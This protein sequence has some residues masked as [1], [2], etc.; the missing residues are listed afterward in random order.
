M[1]IALAAGFAAMAVLAVYSLDKR[2]EAEQATR[3]AREQRA[4]VGSVGSLALA[5]AAVGQ[6]GTDPELAFLLADRALEESDTAEAEAAIG[7]A[8]DALSRHRGVLGEHKGAIDDLLASRR[9]AHPHQRRRQRPSLARPSERDGLR[10][11]PGRPRGRPRPLYTP[12][13]SGDGRYVV[14]DGYDTSYV[15]DAESGE[16][17]AVL[18]NDGVIYRPAIS[19]DGQYVVSPADGSAALW[20]TA[21]E[22][23]LTTLHTQALTVNT[24]SFDP[25]GR[26]VVTAGDDGAARIWTVPGG[27]EVGTLTDGSIS[28]AAF[29]PDGARIVTWGTGGARLWDAATNELLAVLRDPDAD[30]HAVS[31]SPDGSLVATIADTQAMRD[32]TPGFPPHENTSRDAQPAPIS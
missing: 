24:A 25:T 20:E 11:R 13:F 19:P 6:V 16:E 29:S 18:Q 28:N 3:D 17:I 12:S 31:F 8:L 30:V 26:L 15:W 23:L 32:P 5:G 2:R 7:D 14:I 27:E 1:A 21:S 9:D 22:T 4:V 10:R